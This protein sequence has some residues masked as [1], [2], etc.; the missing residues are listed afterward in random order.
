MK[1]AG[2]A[3]WQRARVHKSA[4]GWRCHYRTGPLHLVIT[5][6]YPTHAE[7][8]ER[9]LAEVGVSSTPPEHREAP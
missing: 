8:M 9:A 7:A 6:P 1:R 2:V 5:R 4:D 3:W